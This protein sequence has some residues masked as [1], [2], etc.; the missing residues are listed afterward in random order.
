MPCEVYFSN[1]AWR[2]NK[3]ELSQ[4]KC[5]I[6]Q[7]SHNNNENI[8]NNLYK[9]TKVVSQLWGGESSCRLNEELLLNA[10][11]SRPERDQYCCCASP[12]PRRRPSAHTLHCACACACP[13]V[14]TGTRW[15]TPPRSRGCSTPRWRR[16]SPSA[17]PSTSSGETG[18]RLP[19]I[20]ESVFI[21]FMVLLCPVSF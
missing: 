8:M 6:S 11:T 17:A 20:L 13:S 5:N 9:L 7:F 14:R 19:L 16:T 2:R 10:R 18:A 4:K 1:K 15:P 21:L 3:Y 12:R